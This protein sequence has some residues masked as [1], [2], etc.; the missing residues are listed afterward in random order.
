MRANVY[1]VADP[2]IQAEVIQEVSDLTEADLLRADTIL[3]W[4]H[5]GI[6]QTCSKQNFSSRCVRTDINAQVSVLQCGHVNVFND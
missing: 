1:Y 5:P 2:I 6:Y 3:L 4:P